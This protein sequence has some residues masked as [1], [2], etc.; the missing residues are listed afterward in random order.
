VSGGRLISCGAT[1]GYQAKTDLRHVFFRNLK[2]LG[3]TMASKARLPTVLQLVQEGKLQPVLDR[4]LPLQQA[5]EA[6]QALEQRQ[7]FGKLVLAVE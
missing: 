2:V 6:H 3:A 5:R 7:A 1:L 4:V